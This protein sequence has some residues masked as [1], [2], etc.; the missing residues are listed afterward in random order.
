MGR[1][2]LTLQ[3]IFNIPTAVIFNPDNYNPVTAVTIDSRNVS[4]NSLFVAIKGERFDGHDFVKEAVKK[5][6]S[7][8]MVEEKKYQNFADVKVAVVTVND[9]T[10]ALGDIAKCWRNKLNA[11]VIGITGSAGKTSTKEIMASLLGERFKVNK[12]KANNNNNIGVPLTIL[13]TNS[14]HEVLVIEMGTNHFGEISYTANIA[15]PD[16]ALITNIGSSHLEFLRNKKGVL[17]EKIALFET[18]AS[19]GG[20]IFVN[21]DDALLKSASKKYSQKIS[22]GFDKSA[23]VKGKIA[24]Y[25]KEG[26]PE[27]ELKYKNKILKADFPLYGEGNAK[28]YLAAA[29]VSFE[30]GLNKRQIISGTAKLKAY[31]K[32]LNVREIK[33][34]LLID[35]TY[36]ANPDSMKYSL[37]LLGRIQT[38][39]RKIAVLGDMFELGADGPKLHK[40][41]AAV[42]KRNKVDEVYTV[43]P[44]M[45]NL[46][47]AVKS[48]VNKTKHFRTRKSLENYL[49]KLNF[50]DAAV[51]V[52][53]S[54]GMKMEEFVKVIEAGL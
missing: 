4:S 15:Q 14:K 54:R 41:L 45:K 49:L 51:L 43:G 47:E 44:L 31:N 29:A 30:L 35:D 42:I 27:I 28:N 50:S 9:T 17:K 25:N 1:I 52:K 5:G 22:F 20:T 21:N 32:R 40:A 53:G 48:S 2:R 19:L 39:S 18:T 3:D 26:R 23:D 13:D 10:I 46:A 6:A 12:T 33:N 36:N 16:Y 7:C 24:E 38:K 37:N 11:K 8:V 34:V